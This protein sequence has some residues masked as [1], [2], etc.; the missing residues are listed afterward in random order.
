[1]ADLPYFPLFPSDWLL[2]T[3][4]LTL[5]EK[6]ALLELAC[7][8][9]SSEKRGYLLFDGKPMP[10]ER[11][12][13]VLGSDKQTAQDLLN[14]LL[15][16]GVLEKEL[17][18]GVLFYPSM[19][20]R[21]KLRKTRQEVGKKGGLTTQSTKFAKA[22]PKQP[23]DQFCGNG[24]ESGNGSSEGGGEGGRD[25]PPPVEYPSSFPGTEQRAIE[26][27]RVGSVR[28]TDEQII[29]YWHEAATR[30]GTEITGQPIRSWASYCNSRA[31]K[32]QNKA[33]EKIP[34][35]NGNHHGKPKSIQD[36]RVAREATERIAA[37]LKNRWCSETAGGG[38]SW[39]DPQKKEMWRE[40][41][42]E[43]KSIDQQI[44]AQLGKTS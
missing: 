6:G 30:G 34:G 40:K 22:K 28:A 44:N 19:V 3:K 39:E 24:S 27:A 36:L 5:T 26:W 33:A 1:M 13:R 38:E 21:E 23:P 43:L 31:I 14:T 37:E 17:D 10:L 12:A 35:T 4:S 20:N 29:R 18:S 32:D 42:R 25:L 16:S 41:L 2:E 8:M 7:S 11:V 15:K 9:H